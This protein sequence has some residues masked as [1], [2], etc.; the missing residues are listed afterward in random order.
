MIV[1]NSKIIFT[2]TEQLESWA[3]RGR[4]DGG[5]GEEEQEEERKKEG[6]K[7]KRDR[8]TMFDVKVVLIV[9]S[10]GNVGRW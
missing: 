10:L 9:M 5:G 1:V 4:G 3:E 8:D 2:T 6:R 7:D